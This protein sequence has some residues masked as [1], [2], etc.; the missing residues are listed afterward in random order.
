MST[1]FSLLFDENP[2]W[3]IVLEA[4]LHAEDLL[5]KAAPAASLALATAEMTAPGETT[6]QE[7]GRAP[8]RKRPW[9]G[10]LRQVDDVPDDELAPIH[11]KLIAGG[12]LHFSLEG[13]DAGVVYQVSREGRQ[14]LKLS[15]DEVTDSADQ[16]ADDSPSAEQFDVAV[17][18]QVDS[19]QAA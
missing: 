11:G 8:I 4:Y 17:D 12:W 18:D 9:V 10:R 15:L 7:G 6:A 2:R 19:R 13:R 16:N 5:A 1:E 14:Q 3:R